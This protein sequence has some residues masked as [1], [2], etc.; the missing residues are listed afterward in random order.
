MS[1]DGDWKRS[2]MELSGRFTEML[3]NA[4]LEDGRY[5]EYREHG[6]RIAPLF[7]VFASG[8]ILE[9]QAMAK[10][11]KNALDNLMDVYTKDAGEVNILLAEWEGEAASDFKIYMNDIA[12]AAEQYFFCLEALKLIIEGAERLMT[13]LR[14][15][16]NGLVART[17]TAYDAAA[18]SQEKIELAVATA[19]VGLLSAASGSLTGVIL[20]GLT[21]SIGVKM[22]QLGADN[23]VDVIKSM[24]EQ[25][26]QIVRGVD[27]ERDK[28]EDALDNLCTYVTGAKLKKVRPERPS[29]ITAPS[30]DPGAFGLPP[31][32]QGGHRR[33]APGGELVEE[34]Q[35]KADGPYDEKTVDSGGKERVR[36]R[37]EEQVPR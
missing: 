34:P 4:A 7:G 18:Q 10:H 22:E 9:V 27:V 26:H 32:L 20:A 28:L 15:D 6:P 19:F 25:G 3:E 35:A 1:A 14:E 29:V 16:V 31:H 8:Q 30:F 37:Y 17:L 33:P 36:D 24:I 12:S 5:G 11:V 21:G 2:M 13:K 23:E